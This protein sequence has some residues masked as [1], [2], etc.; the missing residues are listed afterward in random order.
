MLAFARWERYA[1]G[2]NLVLAR[3]I[4]LPAEIVSEPE[5]KAFLPRRNPRRQ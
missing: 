5:R 1:V 2:R 3:P 4:A